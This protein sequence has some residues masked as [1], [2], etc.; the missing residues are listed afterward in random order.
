MPHR[1]KLSA[2]RADNRKRAALATASA[3]FQVISFESATAWE[4]WLAENHAVSVGVWLRFF[5]KGSDVDSVTHDQAL[6]EALCYGWIDGQIQKQDEKSWRQ[7]F[8]PRRAKS[9][10]SKRNIEHVARL[11][12]AKKMKPAGQRQV[13][14]AKADGRWEMAY[15]SPSNMQTPQDFLERLAENKKA[16]AFFKSLTRANTYAIGWRLQTAKKPETREKRMKAILQ[17]LAKGEKFHP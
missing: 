9:I 16:E 14:A 8:T 12:K 15:D 3:G 11:T 1:K 13:E 6:D 2:N 17:M 5:K 7:K 10:W 4:S